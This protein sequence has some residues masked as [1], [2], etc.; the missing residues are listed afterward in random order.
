MAIAEFE[1]K[2]IECS[3]NGQ[4]GNGSLL[5]AP[6]QVL[7]KLVGFDVAMWTVNAV[8]WAARGFVTPPQGAVIAQG[9]WPVPSTMFNNRSLPPF[10]I[11]LFL[12]YKRPEFLS[13]SSASEWTSWNRT[14]FRFK[15]MNHQQKALD[16]CAAALG[17]N[18]LVA[19]ACPAFYLRADYWQ[20]ILNGTLLKN[21][22]FAPAQ[23]LSGHG[24]YTYIDTT[25]PGIAHSEPSH[26]EP[27]TFLNRGGGD[28]VPPEAPPF[29]NG[30]GRPPQDLLKEA[31]QAA[32]ATV[33]ASPT[34]VGSE[35]LYDK[36]V[37]RAE[38][39]AFNIAPELML[40]AR[41]DFIAAATF[42]AMSGIQWLVLP[43]NTR[44]HSSR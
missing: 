31:A 42:S 30:D 8:F 44:A 28:D 38:A 22:H 34:L 10:N 20:H 13:R 5:W 24:R 41:R 23:Y 12:Q 32:R 26:V 36:V 37:K 15:L 2:E 39:F 3:L 29:G 35:S 11:N 7:E 27:L 9:W 40:D 33:A 16:A 19:Y 14:Y 18:G 4:L 1:E 43:A 25:T 6:G 17:P 21:T